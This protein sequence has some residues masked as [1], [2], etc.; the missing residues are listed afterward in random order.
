MVNRGTRAYRFSH[1]ILQFWQFPQPLPILIPS[2]SSSSDH[3][4]SFSTNLQSPLKQTNITPADRASILNW[5]SKDQTHEN[6]TFHGRRQKCTT[7][8]A[9][10][11][12]ALDA[13]RFDW[14]GDASPN[15]TLGR[16]R[17]QMPVVLDSAAA[18]GKRKTRPGLN[19]KKS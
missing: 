2:P 4:A 5:S 17:L 14:L 9:S 19:L 16:F 15:Q 7:F 10:Y 12:D 8:A 18:A 6:A 13:A 1:P 3:P 11:G